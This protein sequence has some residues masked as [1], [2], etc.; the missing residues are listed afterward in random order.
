[1]RFR[2]ARPAT[3][4]AAPATRGDAAP[5][6]RARAGETIL[7]VED[8][9]DVRAFGVSALE[10]LGYR[11][12]QAADG[13]SALRLLEQVPGPRI[14]LLF[15]DVVLPGGMSGRA[16]AEAVRARLPAHPVLFTSGYT[17]SGMRQ[18]GAFDVER[19]LLPKP[20]TIE[21][22]AHTI[23]DALDAA[24]VSLEPDVH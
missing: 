14:D 3:S 24:A 17:P 11:V 20:Y 4:A 9:E 22:L 6:P 16:L 13:A 23:R 5:L 10:G 12:L 7:L 8:D 18:E 1:M 21:Q 15:T 2:D 19:Y